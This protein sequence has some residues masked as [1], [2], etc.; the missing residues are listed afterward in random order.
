MAAKDKVR[1]GDLL[2]S[3][4]EIT[5]A[6]LEEALLEQIRSGLKLGRILIDSGFIAED[7][8]LAILSEQLDTDSVAFHQITPDG[9]MTLVRRDTTSNE[10]HTNHRVTLDQA[11]LWRF[12]VV[13]YREDDSI[14]SRSELKIEVLKTL[15]SSNRS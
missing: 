12:P 2:V 8:F 7:R 14:A 15:G 3:K 11:G 10:W 5:E 1:I 13:A 6:Q 9:N 4:G